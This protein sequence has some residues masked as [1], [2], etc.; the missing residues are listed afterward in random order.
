MDS[1]EHYQSTSCFLHGG[2]NYIAHRRSYDMFQFLNEYR[3][4]ADG[5]LYFSSYFVSGTTQPWVLAWMIYMNSIHTRLV[6]WFPIVFFFVI[7]VLFFLLKNSSKPVHHR[8]IKP[9]LYP[10][11]FLEMAIHSLSFEIKGQVLNFHGIRMLITFHGSFIF[12]NLENRVDFDQLRT[13]YMF[14]TALQ[15]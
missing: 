10:I 8:P 4:I 7:P 15:W 14:K 5:S 3:N 9:C 6:S 13:C 2:T 11:F 1:F 12:G